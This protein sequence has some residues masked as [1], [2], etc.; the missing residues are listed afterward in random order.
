MSSASTALSTPAAR[1]LPSVRRSP[2]SAG[3]GTA[4]A[5]DACTSTAGTPSASSTPCS[6]TRERKREVRE[7]S[8]HARRPR[9]RARLVGDRVGDR[10]L[11]LQRRRA[12]AV[13]EAARTMRPARAGAGEVAEHDRRVEPG[14]RAGPG[15]SA[16]ASCFGPRVAA[17]PAAG[18]DEHDRALRLAC[19]EHPG[20]L[21]QRR[22]ARQLGLRAGAAASR[23]ATITIGVASVEPGR[24][25]MTVVSGRL[26][27]IV[28]P[29]KCWTWTEK[30]PPAVPPEPSQRGGD[31]LREPFVAFA[32]R[33]PLREGGREASQFGERALRPGRRRGRAWSPAEAGAAPARTT[34]IARAMTKA[35]G[36]RGRDAR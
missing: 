17:A 34:A 29:S 7:L 24:S 15:T 20:E 21:E 33:A 28:C 36:P 31:L 35:R 2:A 22:G 5:R 19:R 4:F 25:A 6:P 12:E 26:P 9:V 8:E 1:D 32:A 3:D 27:S 23:W 16:R 14:R 10:A 11:E 13:G 30:P 18:R